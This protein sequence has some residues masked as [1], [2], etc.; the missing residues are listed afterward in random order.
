MR[1]RV[2]G[3]RRHE[4][5][6]AARFRCA[7]VR[8]CSCQQQQQLQRITATPSP[9]HQ[10]RSVRSQCGPTA[11]AFGDTASRAGADGQQRAGARRGGRIAGADRPVAHA[12]RIGWRQWQCTR[13]A[14]PVLPPDS[15]RRHA[16]H[17]ARCNQRRGATAAT[18]CGPDPTGAVADGQVALSAHAQ[19]RPHRR[20][21]VHAR[22]RWHNPCEG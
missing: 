20:A 11:G 9:F 13:I 15:L 17:A 3:A 16:A 22:C 8:R 7:V 2:N 5:E 18:P 12:N 4:Q 21:H 10:R 6:A 19:A 1:Q 14:V